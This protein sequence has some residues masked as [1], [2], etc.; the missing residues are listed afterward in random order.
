MTAAIRTAGLTK[1]Y[2]GRRGLFDL[3]LEVEAG[4]VLGYLGPNGAG[5]TTTIRLLMAMIHPTRGRAEVFGMNCQK[6]A[7]EV[8]RVV[9]YL[10]GE[11][12]QFGGLRG[13]EV[14]SYLAGLRGGVDRARVANL[15]ERLD[16]DLGQRF[17][18]YSRGNKQKLGLLLAFMH[19]PR[20][21]ILDEPTG[22]LDPLNQQEFYRLVEEARQGGATVF[23]SSHV[24]SEVERVCDR[25]A[26]VRAG[27]LAQVAR[28]ED[29]HHIRYHQLEIEFDGEVPVEAVRSAEGV[30]GVRVEGQRLL[31]VVRGSFTPLLAAI[32]QS[33]VVN[34]VSREPTLEEIFLTY[35]RE[36]AEP[37]AEPLAAR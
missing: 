21:L 26:I 19:D 30:E 11:L 37:Q 8:K 12:P 1:D 15:A 36:Q 35:Y 16:L 31:C 33:R 9:G 27:R 24:L 13:K 10:P 20:L 28:L 7:V 29:L 34:L 3:D 32:A 22:G 4:E 18:E 23:L 25:V 5:K 17:R 2:G 6:Q 14:V